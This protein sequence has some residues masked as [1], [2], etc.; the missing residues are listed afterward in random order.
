WVTLCRDSFIELL[1]AR[2]ARAW[3]IRDDPHEHELEHDRVAVMTNLLLYAL[4]DGFAGATTAVSAAT[5]VA[6]S[7]SGCIW[8]L[9]STAFTSRLQMKPITSNPAMMYMVT[10]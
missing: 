8:N 10:L 4:A 6:A 7:V 3:A 5:S 1:S 2:T 9:L